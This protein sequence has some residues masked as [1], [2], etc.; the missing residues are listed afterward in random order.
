MISE[1]FI[2]FVSIADNSMLA[3]GGFLTSLSVF[4]SDIGVFVLNYISLQRCLSEP[5]A[6][7]TDRLYENGVWMFLAGWMT[8]FNVLT[9]IQTFLL[10]S[11]LE[12]KDKTEKENIEQQKDGGDP[13]TWNSIEVY[14]NKMKVSAIF[15]LLL[16]VVQVSLTVSFY[17]ENPMFILSS[18]HLFIDA[19]VIITA[20]KT[21]D[22]VSLNI[23]R[24]IL[25]ASFLINTFIMVITVQMEL[26]TVG[27]TLSLLITITYVVLD[28][29]QILF[30]S[31]VLTTIGNYKKFKNNK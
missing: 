19:F 1:P 8:L 26:D 21:K 14:T 10:K 15:L 17:G 30:A 6:S 23:L 7:C 31:V 13:P 27:K 3:Y 9:I 20:R 16:D 2:I 28:M 11:Q 5:S 29:V 24:I 4:G 22:P 25:F 12:Q 18:S